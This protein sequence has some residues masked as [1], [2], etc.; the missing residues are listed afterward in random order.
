VAVGF[1][2]TLSIFMAGLADSLQKL[3]PVGGRGLLARPSL[4]AW[5]AGINVLVVLLVIGGISFSAIG[6]LRDLADEQGLGRVRLGGASAREELRRV[7]EDTLTAAR[8]LAARPTLQRLIRERRLASL[9]PFLKRACATTDADTCAV[10]VPGA[11]PVAVGR[12]VAW[13]EVLPASAEQGE[14]FLVVASASEPPLAG[15]RAVIGGG[16]TEVVLLRALDTG[17]AAGLGERAGLEVRLVNYLGF[18]AAPVDDF[19]DLHTAALADGRSAA[20]RIEAL[21]MYAASLPVSAV[22]G[23]VVGLIEV[24]LP[25]AAIDSSVRNLITQL[26]ATA[27]VLGLLAVGAGALL[28]GRIAGPMRSL[29]TAASRLGQG[30]FST[31]IPLNGPAEVGTL[32]RTMED[33]RSNLVE[34][35]DTLRQR[36]AEAQAVLQG[37]VEGVFAVDRDRRIRYLNPRAEQLLGIPSAEAVGRF[38][39]DILR[40]AAP[41]GVRPCDTDCPILKARTAGSGRA[42]ERLHVGEGNIRTTIVTSAAMIDDIQVQVVRDETELESARRARDSVL[43]NISH[44]F[45]T[46]LAAQLASIELLRE[47]LD[48]LGP[49]AR[50]DLVRSLERGAIRLTRLIDNLLESV[51]IE[52]GQTTLRQQSVSL[53]DV[54]DDARSQVEALLLQRQ[55]R[56]SIDIPG[57]LPAVDGDSSRLTQV[58]VN[59]LANAGKFAPEG[60]E[61]RVGGASAGRAVLVWVDDEG[62]G[63]PEPAEG[64]IFDRF[65]RGATE[66]PEPGGLGLGLWIVKSIVDRHGGTVIAARTAENRTRFTVTLPRGRN[67]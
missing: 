21:D 48:S 41:G 16:P 10:I 36:E 34:L 44:E 53:A 23:E 2:R 42:T 24:R 28:G 9:E 40:P 38:C 63:V 51:R 54:V 26:L 8:T 59:L 14:R 17:L 3:L 52:S 22:T 66:E 49:E 31:A 43:A 12:P 64:S 29:T 20:Q 47:G 46:P 19:T 5:L 6:L 15:A 32:A 13:D 25:A 30:D 55:Q 11:A 67:A 57:D 4:G 27:L 37:I 18:A 7:A 62:P 33:M 35:T 50:R 56:L 60:S 45:R 58:F 65:H 39:G 61:I 1:A